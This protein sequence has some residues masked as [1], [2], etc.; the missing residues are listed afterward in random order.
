MTAPA[1]LVWTLHRW[2]KAQ[3]LAQ[4]LTIPTPAWTVPSLFVPVGGPE[5]SAFEAAE[6]PDLGELG[7]R[8]KA[9]AKMAA[10]AAHRD[11]WVKQHL[12]E[13]ILAGAF[14][15]GVE[16]R[17]LVAMCE[18]DGYRVV[19]IDDALAAPSE[20]SPEDDGL[21]DAFGP[22]RAKWTADGLDEETIIERT[23][24][25]PLWKERHHS[26]AF[27]LLSRPEDW[28]VAARVA[29]RGGH[30][31]ALAVLARLVIELAQPVL[32]KR[33]ASVAKEVPEVFAPEQVTQI[34]RL[35][36]VRR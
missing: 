20:P 22:L 31:D 33:L 26:A 8:L 13:G 27:F 11:R 5:I 7:T 21:H 29:H 32:L 3:Y 1:M 24:A 30:Q 16:M 12:G 6:R 18:R 15:P 36:P 35:I 14:H 25:L 17:D 10:A 19:H 2:P 28:L 23:L 34:E 4:A 9:L